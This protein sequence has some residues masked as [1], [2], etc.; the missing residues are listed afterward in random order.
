[1]GASNEKYLALFKAHPILTCH[2]L[3][4]MLQLGK[5]WVIDSCARMVLS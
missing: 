1:M 2:C 4:A 5:I 3:C